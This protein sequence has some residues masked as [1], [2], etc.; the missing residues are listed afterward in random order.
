MNSIS[1]RFAFVSAFISL[2]VLAL[3]GGINYF[4]LKKELL[5]EATHKA[6]LIEKNA[7]FEIE[8]LIFGA[9]DTSLK[10][11]H[12][13]E[14]GDF[15]DETIKIRLTNM[16]KY[17]E[18]FFGTTFAFEPSNKQKKLFS[19]YFYKKDNKILYR[20]LASKDYNYIT[21]P[22]FLIPAKLGKPFWSEPYFDEG[23]GNVLMS[24]YSN[25]VFFND[26]LLA[27]LTIDL[28][29]QKIQEMISSI[30]ILDSGYAFI[31]SKENKILA[32]PNTSLVMLSFEQDRIS[33]GEMIEEDDKWFYYV[34]IVNTD[35]TLVIV[36]PENELFASLNFM[37]GVAILLA[38]VGS[39]LLIFSMIFISRR[40]T[41]PLRELINVTAHIAKGDFTKKIAKP[42]TDD[43]ISKLSLAMT[44]MQQAIA[45]QQEELKILAST[46]TLTNLG[47]RYKLIKD[48]NS[49][50]N[51]ALAIVNI[52]NFSELNDFYGYE[53]GD[54]IIKEVGL[55]LSNLNKDANTNIYHIQGDGYVLFNSDINRDEFEQILNNFLN[56]LSTIIVKV[57][58]EYL[59]FNFTIGLSFAG[60]YEILTT[61]DMAL[62]I[63]KRENKSFMVYSEEIS[64]NKEYENNI[65]WT[66]KIK[67][68]IQDD[69]FV[70]VFQPIVNNKT[71]KIEK[72]ESLVRLQDEGKLVSPFFFLEISKKTKLYS[73]ITRIMI[74]K[75]FEKFKDNTLEFSLNL[76]IENILDKDLEIFIVDILNRYNFG[77]RVVFEIVE[78]ES[79][80]NFQEVLRFLNI[81]KSFGCK[82][83]IDDFGTGYSN[84][85]YLMKLSP[86]YIKIDGSLIKEIDIN[87][88]AQ[89][90]V[91][92][93]VGF[94][95]KMGMKTIAE[96]VENEGVLNKVVEMGINYTQ[97]NIFSEPKID[98]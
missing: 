94:A 1:A 65:F 25:P 21:K 16:L 86:D 34:P 15:S 62:Q 79:I 6:K 30:S 59:S 83:A 41:G 38:L 75:T 3:T 12:H 31:L 35:F 77:S 45:K 8:S 71:K 5:V 61:A 4:F 42:K 73:P 17:G 69:L 18:S 40:V 53:K 20:D 49:S 63:A 68:A 37:S 98:L 9:E 14:E 78:S 33:F 82:I 72:Y 92:T 93:I 23:G 58:E 84:F 26:E 96:F 36:F 46:D 89:I 97:G 67:E 85:V 11:K 19:P 47:N 74:E 64:L 57:N 48:M 10:L 66:K 27:I 22:W 90:V 70:P 43:E 88:Q 51:P 7:R 24:T 60:K 52:D 81:V 44:T 55:H 80:E 87:I 91:S 39:I 50:S 56:D 28:S 54:Y 29:L 76:T 95:K 2:I 32:H 13:F